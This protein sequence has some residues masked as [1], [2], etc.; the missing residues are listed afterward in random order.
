VG[1]LACGGDSIVW[2]WEKFDRS[3]GSVLTGSYAKER[4]KSRSTNKDDVLKYS[5]RKTFSIRRGGWIGKNLRSS[6]RD[7]RGERGQGQTD[8][9]K[10]RGIPFREILLERHIRDLEDDT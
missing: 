5:G 7:L 9:K 10:Y 1:K 8:E 6:K 3:W 4:E 2:E